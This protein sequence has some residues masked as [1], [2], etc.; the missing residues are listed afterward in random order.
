MK[1]AATEIILPSYLA[2]KW[3]T[4][5][6]IRTQVNNFQLFDKYLIISG[7]ENMSAGRGYGV[8]EPNTEF[9]SNID[10]YLHNRFLN[11]GIFIIE[12]TH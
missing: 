2:I 10:G 8:Y 12:M 3:E 1:I 11:I 4:V 5:G 7:F 6:W 9:L